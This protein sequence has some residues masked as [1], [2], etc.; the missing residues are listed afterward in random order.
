M[1]IEILPHKNIF[2][3]CQED[4][5]FIKEKTGKTV[6]IGECVHLQ[7]FCAQSK[8]E[9][10]VKPLDTI[11]KIAQ[12]LNITQNELKTILNGKNIFIGQKIVI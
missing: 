7:T 11:A 3:E 12:K 2:V 6:P 10:I 5:E 4:V 8:R 1:R 9:Y